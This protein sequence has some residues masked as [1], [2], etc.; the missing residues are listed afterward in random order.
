[1]SNQTTD[2]AGQVA[3]NLDTLNKEL[4]ENMTVGQELDAKIARCRAHLEE[5]CTVKAKVEASGLLNFPGEFIRKV[6]WC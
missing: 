4:T 2:A 6:A 5:L 3:V 1:M